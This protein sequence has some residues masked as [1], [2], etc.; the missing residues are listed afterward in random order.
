MEQPESYLAPPSLCPV[1]SITGIKLET[2]TWAG[3]TSEEI[4]KYLSFFVFAKLT[5]KKC[6][7][8]PVSVKPLTA[9]FLILR[10]WF[11]RSERRSLQIS[12]PR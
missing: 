10:R 7:F 2:V 4:W 9:S 5:K 1:D 8:L 11:S 12:A 6:L 3:G